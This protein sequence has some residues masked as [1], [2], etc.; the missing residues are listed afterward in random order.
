MGLGFYVHLDASGLTLGGGSQAFSKPVLAECREA[1][2]DPIRGARL[3]EAL[4]AVRA[5]GPYEVWGNST[6]KRVPS[7]YNP[8]HEN[9]PL[10]LHSGLSA[11]VSTPWLAEIHS[12]AFL[13]YCFEHLG[14]LG[15]LMSWLGALQGV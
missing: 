14:N 5:S 13:D 15:P 7:G 4:A 10:L 2:V 6:Y 9:A 1:V 11:G 8:D 12:A 3:R